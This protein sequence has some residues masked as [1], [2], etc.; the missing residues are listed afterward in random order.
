MSDRW[1]FSD[2]KTLPVI[3]L[4]RILLGE[5]DVRLVIHDEEGGWQFLDGN[6]VTED[7]AGMIELGEV[8]EHDPTLVEVAALPLGFF[9]IRE[10]VDSPWQV[11]WAGDED[12]EGE[13][14]EADGEA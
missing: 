6:D 14:G 4:K 12:D 8:V 7:D 13:D 1:P 2:D 10:S 5:S 9:A 11:G 3:S